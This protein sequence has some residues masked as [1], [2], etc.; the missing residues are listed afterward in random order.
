LFFFLEIDY[1][2]ICFI[3]LF[4]H[5]YFNLYIYKIIV[6]IPENSNA[7]SNY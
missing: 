5:S 1:L 7:K 3:L 4:S 6:I 2:F